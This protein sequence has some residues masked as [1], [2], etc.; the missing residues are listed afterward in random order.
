MTPQTERFRQM[1]AG[2]DETI[3]L[4]EAALLI[5]AAEYPGLDVDACLP[6]LKVGGRD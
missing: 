3:N 4:A 1:V 6:G 5:A 2:P